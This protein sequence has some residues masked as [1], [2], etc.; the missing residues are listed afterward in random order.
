MVKSNALIN[1]DL[2]DL[3]KVAINLIDKCSDAIGGI[4]KPAQIRRVARAEADA[5]KIKTLSNIEN[6]KLIKRAQDRL[7][8][9]E[10]NKQKN[11]EEIIKKA[12][13]QLQQ[14][15]QPQNMDNDWI[16]HFFEKGKLISDDE[17][18]LLWSR[19]LAGEANSPGTYSKR[20]VNFLETINRNEAALFQTLCCYSWSLGE[21]N[22]PLMYDHNA[23]IYK[24]NG[25]TFGTLKHFE[26]I[27]LLSFSDFAFNGFVLQNFPKNI[28][29][30]YFEEMINIEFPNE[31]DNHLEV[32]HVKLSQIGQELA[33]ICD[34]KPIPG[35]FDYVL[36][37]WKNPIEFIVTPSNYL[38]A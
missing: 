23:E 22:V 12:T 36:N 16:T 24:K 20:T 2:H 25:I 21:N 33:P 14:N 34:I 18:Q 6:D 38:T 11:I 3:P 8:L 5:A 1:I 19:V 10:A 30:S 17:M 7:L 9:E 27:G 32:G 26:E 28:V 29:C 15:A 37:R 35:F 31:K 13:P 4:A